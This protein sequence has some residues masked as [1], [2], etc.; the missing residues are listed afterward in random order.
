MP[1]DNANNE[2]GSRLEDLA[3]LRDTAASLQRL[4]STIHIR[5]H[6]HPNAED[7]EHECNRLAS[8]AIARLDRELV[9]LMNQA[10]IDE[11]ANDE[12]SENE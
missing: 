6:G 10:Y 7:L 4:R 5:F 3:A 12:R 9:A 1:K 8:F 11:V 2:I